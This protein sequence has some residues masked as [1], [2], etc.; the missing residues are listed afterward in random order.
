[1]AKN[2][3][4]A[5]DIT[6]ALQS[7]S[8]RIRTST[9]SPLLRRRFTKLTPIERI[10]YVSVAVSI[11]VLMLSIVFIRMK[12]LQITDS[13][14]TMRINMT[15]TQSQIDQSNQAIKDMTATGKVGAAAAQAG[16]SN[17]AA[18]ILKASK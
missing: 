2:N 16:L 8:F 5:L 9:I 13:T 4:K 7:E 6:T 3:K 12:T 11:L 1:M 17:N 15:N 18:N 14:N 10:F